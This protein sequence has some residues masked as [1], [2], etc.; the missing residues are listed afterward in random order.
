MWTFDSDTDPG[1]W[2]AVESPTNVTL[3]DVT[4]TVNGPV[5]VGDTGV[6]VG[7]GRERWGVILENGPGARSQTLHAVDASDDGE[8]LWFAGAGGAFGYYDLRTEER[9]DHSVPRGNANVFYSLTV[10]GDRGEEKFLV[11][12]GSG[13]VLPGRVREDTGEVDWDWST[14]PNKGNAV[15][16]LTHDEEG[17]GYAVDVSSNVHTTTANEGWDRT[18]VDDAQGSFYDCAFGGGRLLVGG[19]NGRVF[20]GTGVTDRDGEAVWTPSEL[21]GFAVYGIDAG[22]GGQLACGEGG[23]VYLRTADGEWEAGHYDGT[24]TFRAGL[25]AE[26]MVLVGANGLIVERRAPEE[27]PESVKAQYG[28]AEADAA[29]D[30]TATPSVD[31]ERHDAP[32]SESRDGGYGEN[33]AAGGDS[34]TADGS[35]GWTAER[36]TSADGDSFDGRGENFDGDGTPPGA[37]ATGGGDSDNDTADEPDEPDEEDTDAADPPD[38]DDDD[39]DPPDADTDSDADSPDRD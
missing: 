27:T 33:E 34:T 12:D 36:T 13:N 6:A 2:V 14:S 18:G 25:V 1:Y 9:R 19:G 22:N 4:S 30:D 38:E 24:E 11:G 8:R 35:D 31:W 21:G 23:H 15:E 5:A 37:P 32:G 7:R 17:Y 16:A 3:R 20:E 28:D 29:E 26:Q 10:F 39:A